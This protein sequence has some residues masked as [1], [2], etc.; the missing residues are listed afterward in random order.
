VQ[1]IEAGGITGFQTLF[2]TALKTDQWVTDSLKHY[3]Q[4]RR[5]T[6]YST[7]YIS[8]TVFFKPG[9]TSFTFFLLGYPCK[10]RY[11]SAWWVS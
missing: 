7:T 4:L 9:I 5:N 8:A 3:S 11:L 1:A 2:A 10:P 6:C